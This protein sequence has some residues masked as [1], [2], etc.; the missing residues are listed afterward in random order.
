MH[1]TASQIEKLASAYRRTR[2]DPSQPLMPD[3]FVP[4]D[5]PPPPGVKLDAL[6][7]A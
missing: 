2:V 3:F 6:T 1:A 5:V 4:A 7:P